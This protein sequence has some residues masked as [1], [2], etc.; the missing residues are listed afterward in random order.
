MP[1]ALSETLAAVTRTASSL[2]TGAGFENG[3][4]VEHPEGP[5]AA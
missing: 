5:A 4:L 1:S 3:H 2:W